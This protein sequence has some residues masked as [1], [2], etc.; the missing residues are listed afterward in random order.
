MKAI[1]PG[2]F[3]PVTLGHLNLIKRGTQLFDQIIVA[4]LNNPAKSPLFTIQERI[5]LLLEATKDISGIQIESYNGLLA[6]FAKKHK[7]RYILRGIRTEADCAYE[8]PM[9]QAN[10]KLADGPETVLLVAEP[11]Y[12]YISAKLIREIAAAGYACG[13]SGVGSSDGTETS[14]DSGFDD[15]V[16]DQWVTPAVKNMLKR[17]YL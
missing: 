8:I 9:I 2:S 3:D 11:T 12:A 16:L 7:A 4:V 15:G 14:V 17:K 6:E 5:D 10:R 13:G 1:F